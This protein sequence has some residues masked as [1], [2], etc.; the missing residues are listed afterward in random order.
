MRTTV[1][2][3]DEALE[4]CKD[5][6][7]QKGISLGEAIT[8]AIL[9]T[10]RDTPEKTRYQRFILPVSGKGGLRPGV[11]LDSNAGLEDVME[12]RG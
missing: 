9:A 6:A 12:E 10:Y 11:D 2:I 8:E 1:N 3:Q 4:L 5:K 7:Q